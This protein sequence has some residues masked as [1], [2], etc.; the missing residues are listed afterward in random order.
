MLMEVFM[1]NVLYRFSKSYAVIAVLIF[2]LMAM[3]GCSSKPVMTKLNSPVMRIAID[4][5]S[6][7]NDQYI[8][9]Q[10]AL[11]GSGKWIIVDR[12]DG[13]RAIKKE[14]E[15]L[16]QDE[17]D[18]FDTREKYARWGK[19]YG[20][21]GIV[22]ANLQCERKSKFFS[23]PYLQCLQSISLVHANTGEVLAS[24]ELSADS[25]P[26]WNAT[27]AWEDSVDKFN[28]SIPKQIEHK[29]EQALIDYKDMIEKDQAPA[30]K[31][32]SEE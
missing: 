7:P 13:Y 3:V 24:I 4:S 30:K 21:G 19:M 22:V 17:P 11:A 29:E 6:I 1:E 18:R 9:L 16:H 2:A 15:R 23:G 27:P 5:D 8:R 25:E 10:T 28:K 32:A 26:G 31:P 20:V 12:G 14:Q